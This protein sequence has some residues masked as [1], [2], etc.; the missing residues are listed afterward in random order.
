VRWHGR[1]KVEKFLKSLYHLV[2]DEDPHALV[3]YVNFPT[4]EFLNLDFVDFYSFNV[5]LEQEDNLRAYL[6][7]LQVLWIVPIRS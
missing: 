5:Y 2:K 1:K 3:T 7:R 4:T 6:S